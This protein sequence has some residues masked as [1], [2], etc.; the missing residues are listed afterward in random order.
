MRACFAPSTE[1]ASLLRHDV[2]HA[3]FLVE[4]LQVADGR[5]LRR[6]VGEDVLEVRDQHAELRA[7]VAH[8]V[9]AQRL[10]PE[11]LEEAE[12]TFRSFEYGN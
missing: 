10:V 9:D 11:E 6:K 3:L 5:R 4:G 1:L 7:P 2:H 12:Q 8:V